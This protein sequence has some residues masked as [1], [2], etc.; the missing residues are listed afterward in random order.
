MGWGP[1]CA[2]R[3][4]CQGSAFLSTNAPPFQVCTPSLLLPVLFLWRRD[5]PRVRTHR[6]SLRR[7]FPILQCGSA[8]QFLRCTAL[9]VGLTKATKS[10][11]WG[12]M[13]HLTTGLCSRQPPAR[14]TRIREGGNG[15]EGE[16]RGGGRHASVCVCMHRVGKQDTEA[17]ESKSNTPGHL[18]FQ[19]IPGLQDWTGQG[20]SYSSEI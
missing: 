12:R 13:W 9:W 19:E 8:S 17:R 3:G 1:L 20:L 15:S 16:G 11:T 18:A 5:G 14:G 2:L 7:Q 10:T 4:C 6:S